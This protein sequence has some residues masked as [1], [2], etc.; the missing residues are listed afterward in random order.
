MNTK[1][2]NNEQVIP[3][4]MGAEIAKR[5][6][7]MTRELNDDEHEL[8]E[9]YKDNLWERVNELMMSDDYT[10]QGDFDFKLSAWVQHLCIV[11]PAAERELIKQASDEIQIRFYAVLAAGVKAAGEEAR[12]GNGIIELDSS[13]K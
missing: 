9:R 5:S 11:S 1:N 10:S 12:K 3:F 7:S 4:P 8:I 13:L 2:E 6:E